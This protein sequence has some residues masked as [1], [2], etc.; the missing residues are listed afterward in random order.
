MAFQLLV[1]DHLLLRVGKG[2]E[3]RLPE[4]I[5][6]LDASV[7]EPLAKGGF[8]DGEE[9][10]GVVIAT[11]LQHVVVDHALIHQLLISQAADFSHRSVVML[12]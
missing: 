1:V 7:P 8:E 9:V 4:L 10:H 5:V 12:A 11:A 6:A 3:N 2:I